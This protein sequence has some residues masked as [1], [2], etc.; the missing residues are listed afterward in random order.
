MPPLEK[1]YP[2]PPYVTPYVTPYSPHISEWNS[3]LGI[4]I[5]IY[6]YIY[7]QVLVTL[8]K[9]HW[10][11]SEGEAALRPEKRSA[12]RVCFYKA[13]SVEWHPRGVLGAIVP[14]NYPFH[15]IL[16][17]VSA[18][19]F[20]GNAIIVKVS[21]HSLWSSRFYGR[22][23]SACLS[24]AGAPADLVQLVSGDGSAGAALTREADL[25]TFVGSTRVGKMVPKEKHL[26]CLFPNVAPPLLP[27]VHNLIQKGDGDGAQKKAFVLSLPKCR[28]P[29]FAICPQFIS[30]R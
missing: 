8:E 1:Y 12:G 19:V 3:I 5:Y 2:F 14:W 25:M 9:L 22:L 11:I 17:P 20:S 30:K 15:N 16:N 24:A 13:A 27:Y 4:H 7:I 23:I 18:A 29:T 28:T 6:I 26:F 21:E 10:L